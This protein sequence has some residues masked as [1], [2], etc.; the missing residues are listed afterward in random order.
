MKKILLVITAFICIHSQSIHAAS[1]GPYII[2]PDASASS[3][4]SLSNMNGTDGL[5]S[6]TDLSLTTYVEG[7]PLGSIGLGFSNSLFNST[8][9]DLAF[10]FL[11][12]NGEPDTVDFGLNING[13]DNNYSASLYTYVDPA[14]GLTK[15]YQINFGNGFA[16][17]FIATVE[18]GD[19]GISGN[20]SITGLTVTDL[21]STDRL[22]LAAG[23]NLTADAPAPVPLPAAVW[24]FMT[25]LGALGIISRRR[26]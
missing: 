20:N 8:G 9:D 23:F 11:R 21:N 25:G 16:D 14:D 3:V 10:Y 19:F 7:N 17:M 22:A 6:I 18:L 15:K 1:I 12:A 5:S 2:D 4:T 24:L 26:K 13:I